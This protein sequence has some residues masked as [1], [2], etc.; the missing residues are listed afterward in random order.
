MVCQGDFP[1]TCWDSTLCYG[2]VLT[3]TQLQRKMYRHPSQVTRAPEAGNHANDFNRR[4]HETDVLDDIGWDGAAGHGTLTIV[5]CTAAVFPYTPPLYG[6]TCGGAPGGAAN[7]G[8]ALEEM[9]DLEWAHAMAPYANILMVEAADNGNALYA[10]VHYAA[11]TGGA[12]I[13]SDSWGGGEYTGQTTD[14]PTFATGKP[15][16]FSSGDNGDMVCTAVDPI[17]QA[18]TTWAVSPQ[19][20]CSSPY[21]TCVGGT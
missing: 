19:Y 16:L 20:P 13:V 11:T 15:I 17:T 4:I 9:L 6:S 10:G 7:S 1:E 21:V 5:N 18:C 2:L 3:S 8:W 14:D 12:D